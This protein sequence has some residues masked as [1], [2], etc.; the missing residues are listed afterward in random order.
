MLYKPTVASASGPATVSNT[1]NA[2]S[3][4]GL[5][6]YTFSAQSFGVAQA[7]RRIAVG[8]VGRAVASRT[9]SS[10]TIGGV[11]ATEVVFGENAPGL[12]NYAVI[13]IADV[14]TGVDGDVVITWSA[15]LARC[16]IS[17]YRIVGAG[18]ATAHDT[19]S[20]TVGDPNVT[21][22]IPDNGCAIGIGQV[23]GATSAVWTGLTENIDTGY[24][25]STYSSA[26]DNFVAGTDQAITCN[27]GAGADPVGAF[28]SWGP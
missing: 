8:I 19:G 9:I 16:A 5:T 4:S 15:A 24:G 26:S 28:A 17:V 20:D 6:T 2:N 13:Y 11:S 10:V 7:D 1:A 23:G 3:A 22:T 14:P 25:S 12:A 18:S 27:F 21:L